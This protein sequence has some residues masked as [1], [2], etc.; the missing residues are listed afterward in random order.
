MAICPVC[1]KLNEAGTRNCDVCGAP[2]NSVGAPA[3]AASHVG[4]AEPQRDAP[5]SGPVC[6]VCRR[7]NRSGSV[8]CAYC[9]YRFKPASASGN[10]PQP[11]VLP[12]TNNA[13]I[14]APQPQQVASAI[15][16]TEA[17]NIPSGTLLKRRYR[18]MRKIAQGGM[19]AVYESSD[20]TAPTGTRWAVKEISPSAMPASERTQAV[21][22]FRREA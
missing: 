7:G 10:S 1:G 12:G 6:P 16:S 9:G 14:P 4:I 20:T 22:D 8:F 13:P 19:G 18:I 2:L 17:G 3:G 11:Y 5:M 15:P 21:A